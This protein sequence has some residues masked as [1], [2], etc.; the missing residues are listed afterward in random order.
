MRKERADA[1][2]A[3][4]GGRP[5][6]SARLVVADDD[7]AVRALLGAALAAYTVLPAAR[8][9]DALT[10]IRRERPDLAVLDVQMPGLDGLAVARA[11]AADPATAPLP[12][13][14]CSGAGPEAAAAAGPLAGVVAFLPKPF[15]LVELLGTVARTLR[16]PP[17]AAP[18][19]GRPAGVG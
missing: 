2:D 12:V 7:D 15:D 14:L 6:M 3:A 17:P 11:L 8:G 19:H 10:L 5:R 13:V 18:G 1:R 4:R 16:R 9:D